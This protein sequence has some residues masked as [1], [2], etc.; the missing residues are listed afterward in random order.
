MEPDD[1]RLRHG[2]A[3]GELTEVL[4]KDNLHDQP[5]EIAEFP[6]ILAVTSPVNEASQ[7]LGVGCKP[8]E[9]MEQRLIRLERAGVDPTVQRTPV[10]ELIDKAR[11]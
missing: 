6:P 3:A 10:A 4:A 11:A 2:Q 1:L 8:G 7:D 9:A 5:L